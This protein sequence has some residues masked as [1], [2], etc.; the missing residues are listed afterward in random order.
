MRQFLEELF[1]RFENNYGFNLHIFID[2]KICIY[3]YFMYVWKFISFFIK[4][5]INYYVKTIIETNKFDS[6]FN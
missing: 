2:Y 3:N 1:N 6:T 4:N 5:N